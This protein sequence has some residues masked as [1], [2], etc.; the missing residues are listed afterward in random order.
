M[1]TR[2]HKSPHDPPAPDACDS[3][4]EDP[5]DGLLNYSQWKVVNKY[6][7]RKV[8][9]GKV[10]QVIPGN[11]ELVRFEHDPVV[12]VS[13]FQP[14]LPGVVVSIAGSSSQDHPFEV[15]ADSSLSQNDSATIKVFYSPELNPKSG[16][17][18]R[19]SDGWVLQPY[20]IQDVECTPTNPSSFEDNLVEEVITFTVVHLEPVKTIFTA[21][22]MTWAEVASLNCPRFSISNKAHAA[23]STDSFSDSVKVTTNRK[24]SCS[25][26]VQDLAY[27]EK[28]QRWDLYR[29]LTEISRSRSMIRGRAA[30][31]A[32]RG[33]ARLSDCANAYLRV[34]EDPFSG[35]VACLPGT[36][37][38]PTMKHSVRASGTFST[39]LVGFGYV[40]LVPYKGMFLDTACV[41]GSQTNYN[42]ES[43]AAP[44]TQG[45]F[46]VPTNSPYDDSLSPAEIKCRLVAA[47]LRVRNVTA[48][49]NRGGSL[50][51]AE[52]LN[53]S[54]VNGMDIPALM[55][56]DTTER[57]SAVS[58][59]WLS[60]V[61]HPQDEDETDFI[62]G[63]QAND[64]ELYNV[65]TL[66][67][68]AQNGTDASAQQT[69]EWEAYVVFEAK[70]QVVHGLTPSMSD[71]VGL[72]AAQNA[73]AS[74][75]ARKPHTG[76]RLPRVMAALGSAANYVTQILPPLAEVAA[77]VL[78]AIRGAPQLLRGAA[79]IAR[80]AAARGLIRGARAAARAAYL[81]IADR[82]YST[83]EQVPFPVVLPSGEV[84]IAVVFYD[85]AAVDTGGYSLDGH[86]IQGYEGTLNVETGGSMTMA[87]VNTDD[88]LSGLITYKQGPLI[89][90]QSC[91][92]AVHRLI[93]HVAGKPNQ[94][95]TGEWDH[96]K[97]TY[98]GGTYYSQKAHQLSALGLSLVLRPHV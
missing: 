53:H 3:P 60:V 86:I 98:R 32:P 82:A 65:A 76:A 40:C 47:G 38:F 20:L 61:W 15:L 7:I 51:G 95:F 42:G 68:A 71:P 39:G 69:Y 45:Q 9:F 4:V 89:V 35:Q 48:M 41:N 44:N 30:R 23:L 43:I 81:R 79:R 94:V 22:T 59:D 16:F 88:W 8:F 46:S 56:M 55:L 19:A 85:S 1:M 87:H 74:V 13:Y 72:A 10:V 14:S 25:L 62:T 31:S 75:A 33:R 49:L 52:S 18:I 36:P 50:V 70:G 27:R 5:L 64:S 2:K 78:P 83:T 26:S 91:Q 28:H 58:N 97:N 37:N 6:L 92:H 77:Q 57:L 73:T 96:A 66:A 90:D 93:H 21:K 12:R 29:W 67:F 11:N 54:P 34:L 63:A 84:D 24:A 17:S 80:V